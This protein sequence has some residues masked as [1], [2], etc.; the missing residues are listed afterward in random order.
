MP[1]DPSRREVPR[2]LRFPVHVLRV[3][4]ST[5]R[6][7]LAT[8]RYSLLAAIVLG[9]VLLALTVTAQSA[10]PLIVYPFA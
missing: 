2:A 4:G 3:L 7:S 6:F 9:L 8:R 10:A 5:V 1:A